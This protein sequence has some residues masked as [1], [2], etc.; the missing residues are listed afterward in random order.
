MQKLNAPV[1][2]IGQI[3][4]SGLPLLSSEE[5]KEAQKSLM[6]AYVDAQHILDQPSKNH[7]GYGYKYDYLNDDISSIQAAT[8]DL[9]IAYIQQP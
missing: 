1:N 9:D 4:F 2:W 6:K 7:D 8:N 3:C 5:L